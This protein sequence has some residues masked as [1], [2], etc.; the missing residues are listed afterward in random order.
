MNILSQ[1]GFQ[2]EKSL[3]VNGNKGNII[4]FFFNSILHDALHLAPYSKM[5]TL[6]NVYIFRT[7]TCH[8]PWQEKQRGKDHDELLQHLKNVENLATSGH[9]FTGEKIRSFPVHKVLVT[10]F[11][12]T[13]II[14]VCRIYD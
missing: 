14:V 1:V 6:N 8:K 10:L 3:D 7:G 9:V 2:T 4:K 12:A 11:Y 5:K 13:Q